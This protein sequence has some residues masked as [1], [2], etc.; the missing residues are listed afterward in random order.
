MTAL[1]SIWRQHAKGMEF[2]E[3]LFE[4]LVKGNESLDHD[5]AAFIEALRTATHADL[6]RWARE[7]F[8]VE[9]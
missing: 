3:F 7:R 4:A 6:L 5:D 9:E 8:G 2:G 1:I